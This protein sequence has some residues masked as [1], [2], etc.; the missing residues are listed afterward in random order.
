MFG[1][2]KSVL[3]LGLVAMISF[4]LVACG[5]EKAAETP[6][7]TATPEAA[8]PEAAAPATTPEATPADSK[9]DLK[10]NVLFATFE[11][12]TSNYNISAELGKMWEDQGLGTVDVQPI[13]PG[14]MGAPYLFENGKADIAFINGA[15]AR[16]AMETGTLGKA[17]TSDYRA[18][19]GELSA[20]SAVNFLTQDFI[21][22]Y[23][24]TT[25]E[26]A[27]RQKLPIRIGCSPVGSMDNEVV[28]ILLN[29][30]GATE[31]DIKAWG[32]DVV[33]GG[34]S[35]LS[36]MVKDGKLDFMLD[37]TSVNS[38][39]MQEIAMT[40]KVKFLQWEEATIDH[41]V[42][43]KGF[44]RV[45]IAPNS[46]KGQTEELVNAG[47]PD[48]LFVKADLDEEVVYQLTKIMCE[49]RDQLVT[50]FASL[51][52]FRPETCWEPEKVGG[53]A[54]H[55]GAERYFKEMGYMK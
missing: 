53:V 20:V 10:A 39:T 37:H 46:W 12:G 33:H 32:G 19:L 28:Q 6:A 31:E 15:P 34:G 1:L 43:E 44:Q 36:A 38:S 27:I 17:P 50:V 25:I 4:S 48:C 3:A 23:K 2:K 40:S 51:E 8:A 11:V 18:M 30:M 16:W 26:E 7:P 9:L 24:V 41:F 45:I 29:Y 35:D 55:P 21:D 13:S 42:K 5:G 47:T 14:G 49:N 22:K 54:L 52:P